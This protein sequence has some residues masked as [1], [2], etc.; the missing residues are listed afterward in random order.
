MSLRTSVR[1][2]ERDSKVKRARE[3]ELDSE[4]ED[5]ETEREGQKEGE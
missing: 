4:T 5:S 2:I 3:S 1:G